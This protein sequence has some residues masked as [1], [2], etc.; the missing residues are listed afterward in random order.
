M[1][2]ETVRKSDEDDGKSSRL[3]MRVIAKE[4]GVS[5]TTVSLALRGDPSIS[6]KTKK[7]IFAIQ[8]SLGYQWEARNRRPEGS[9]NRLEQVIYRFTG[10]DFRDESY[11]P[12]LHG[13]TTECRARSI[14]LELDVEAE[15]Q[16]LQP[17]N[18]RRGIILSGRV[19]E[20]DVAQV[21][22]HGL[23]FVV[24]GNVRLQ[25][26]TPMNIV[27]LNLLE[28]AS[29]ALEDL[30]R[31]GIRGITFVVEDPKRP[32]ERQMLRCL[33]GILLDLGIP[34]GDEHILAAGMGFTA[35]QEV[36]EQLAKRK[37]KNSCVLTIEP[38]CADHLAME[39]RAFPELRSNP[40]QLITFAP[41]NLKGVTTRYRIFN[42][43]IESCGAMA[44]S[45]LSDMIANPDSLPC[46]IFISSPGWM[47]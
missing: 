16:P 47:E 30:H 4:A 41:S 11:A 10:L 34:A 8:Q 18:L 21:R 44:V 14:K 15:S 23:P 17:S 20:K 37:Q 6:E 39:L 1:S 31:E 35:M 42:F 19:T 33:R 43:G 7:R 32:F 22:S 27:G 29:T 3:N 13:I 45:R 26:D 36:A 5:A 38:H 12:F 2:K 9:S 24:L 46:A 25:V 28:A 40:I